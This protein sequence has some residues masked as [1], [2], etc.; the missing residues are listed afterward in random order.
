MRLSNISL[1]LPR[2]QDVLLQLSKPLQTDR[3]ILAPTI[4]LTKTVQNKILNYIDTVHAITV[5][6]HDVVSLIKN[7]FPFGSKNSSYSDPHHK[8]IVTG[9]LRCICNNKFQK[10]FQQGSNFCQNKKD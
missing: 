10:L 8:H 5:M 9:D 6:A 3:N 1:S 4:K 7:T 2:C